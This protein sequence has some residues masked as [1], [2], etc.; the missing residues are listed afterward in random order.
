MK[1]SSKWLREWVNPKVS[2][3]KLAEKLTMSGIEVEG[4]HSI[5]ANLEHIVVGQIVSFN[6]H[7]NADRLNV[8]EIDIADGQNLQI[9]CG[10]TNVSLNMKVAVAKIGAKLSNNIKIK[11]SKIRDVYSSGMLCSEEEL[12]I[13][14]LN[15]GII[16]ID[17]DANLGDN[18]AKY[19]DLDDKV[20]ELDITPNRGDCFS[21]LGIAREIAAIYDLKVD[22]L[23]YYNKTKIKNDIPIKVFNS[24]ACPKYLTRI[25][26][27]IDNKVKTPKWIVARLTKSAQKTHSAVVDII[28][29]VLLEMG[30]PMHAFDMEKING[31]INVRMASSGEKI[32]LLNAQKITLRE[33]TLVIADDKN[34]IAIAGIIGGEESSTQI[35]SRDILI[36]SAFFEQKSI[37]GIARSYGLNTESSIRFERGVDFNLTHQALE[38]ATEL[39]LDICGGEATEIAEFIDI[40]TLPKLEPIKITLDKIS[41]VI[42]FKLDKEWIEEK[43]ILLGFDIINKNDQFFSVAV[44]SFRFDIKLDVDIIEELLRLYGYDL[45]PNKNLN[46]DASLQ[47]VSQSHLSNLEL[48]QPLINKGYQEVITYSFISSK[49]SDIFNSKYKNIT[50]INPISQDMSIMRASL[51]PGLLQTIELNQR[52]GNINSR[53]FE[54]GL[55]FNGTNIE[56]QVYKIAGAITGKRHSNNWANDAEDVD[57]FDIKADVESLLSLSSDDFVFEPYENSDLQFGQSAKIIKDGN[58]IGH[59]GLLSPIIAKK[60]SLE[61]VFLF[62]ILLAEISNCNISSYNNFSLF[63]SSRRDISLVIK[64][65]IAFSNII[66]CIKNLKQK[67]LIDVFIFD[68]YE[69]DNI[70]DDK[71]SIALGLKYQSDKETLKDEEINKNVNQIVTHLRKEFYA[72]LR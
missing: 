21:I 49:Y 27:N 35:E 54:I 61:K 47:S 53:F 39:I 52:R 45:I 2:D 37:S 25:I 65:D 31:G 41:K 51:F 38:R 10:A 4:I 71:K 68:V 42:G 18:I 33:D 72:E 19:L 29:Y 23:K 13:S 59:L 24:R 44:P 48:S 70:A 69:T 7:P 28:N 34:P 14:E 20:F 11:K 40:Q 60:L 26:K 66:S 22:I 15:E 32:E 43:I 57:F 16:E 63:Q 56:Q 55:C 46:I 5:S 50:I 6:K 3:K 58:K 17:C 64:K 8:C 67:Y 36:E 62:E 12:G 9:I 30:Q 1:I